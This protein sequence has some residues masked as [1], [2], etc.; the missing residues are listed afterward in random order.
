MFRAS[1]VLASKSLQAKTT[2]R[3]A[4]LG[5]RA[6]SRFSSEGAVA[7][8]GSRARRSRYPVN[9]CPDVRYVTGTEGVHRFVHEPQKS[10]QIDREVEFSEGVCVIRTLNGP[11]AGEEIVLTHPVPTLEMA[12]GTPPPTHTFEESPIVKLHPDEAEEA[13]ALEELNIPE[14]PPGFQPKDLRE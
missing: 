7:E 13:A 4:C 3:V 9:P 11:N 2:S 5:L 10:K 12:I 8:V 1:R 14:A 6:V